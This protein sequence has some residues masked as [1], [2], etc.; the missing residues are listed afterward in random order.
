MVKLDLSEVKLSNI[1]INKKSLKIP[2]ILTPELAEFLGFHM[3]DGHMSI[4][5]KGKSVTYRMEYFSNLHKEVGYV[6]NN[7]IPLIQKL[8]NLRPIPIKYYRDSTY[9]IRI[10]SRGLL[11][12]LRSVG[13]PIGAKHNHGIPNIIKNNKQFIPHFLR[14]LADADFGFCLKNKE[15]KL[16]PVINFGTS[17]RKLVE[18]TSF[19]L[20]EL[21]I[22]HYLGLDF[23]Y[24]SKQFKSE[25]IKNC[26]EINGI[27]N[28]GRWLALINFNNPS[29]I[30][31]LKRCRELGIL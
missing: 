31:T 7:I 23:K 24:T 25:I 11:T 4:Y 30:K 20:K 19:C 9:I 12:F 27:K 13:I 14:G 10:Y 8:F 18:D 2:T 3:G 21:D 22:R 26:V 16:Y 17:N 15:G 6:D 29:K 5:R 28:V 1:D